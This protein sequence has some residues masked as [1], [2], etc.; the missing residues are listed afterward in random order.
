MAAQARRRKATLRAARA[1]RVRSVASGD[2]GQPRRVHPVHEVRARLPR[3]TGQRRHRLRLP[4]RALEDRVRPRRPDGRIDLRRLRRMRAGVPDRRA[5]TRARRLSRGR[6]PHGAVGLSVLR[7]RLP[8]HLSREGRRDRPRRGPRRSGEPRAAVREGPLRLRLRPPSAAVDAAADPPR[9]RAEV[10][11]L[12][13]GSRARAGRLPRSELGRGALARRGH[14]HADPRRARPEGAR[15]VR[16]GEGLERGSVSVPEARAHG[17]RLEQRRPLHAALPRVQRRGAPRRH[18]LGR[19]VEP[20]D[21]RPR[22]P[23][24]SS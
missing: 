10:G 16:L 1:A 19:G 24:S 15:G 5:R 8:D 22:R 23:R 21:G 17:L 14:A 7:S 9:R 6:G 11:G 12:H 3:G 2:G 13:D 18:R 20:G 4:R